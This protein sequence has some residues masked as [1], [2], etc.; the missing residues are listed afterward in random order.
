MIGAVHRA[1]ALLA[2]F[3]LG[4][5]GSLLWATSMMEIREP[6]LTAASV[7]L[8]VQKEI[9]VGRPKTR[10]S[11]LKPS[12]EQR[13]CGVTC[14]GRGFCLSMIPMPRM[15]PAELLD[16]PYSAVSPQAPEN[17][18]EAVVVGSTKARNCGR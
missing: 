10:P 7:R 2:M 16:A 3:F 8:E 18:V 5:L 11:A 14:K 13:L 12:T 15:K 17:I 4:M 6:R 1:A 9:G